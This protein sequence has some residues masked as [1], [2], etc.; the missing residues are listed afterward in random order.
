MF[1]DDVENPMVCDEFWRDYD[2]NEWLRDE[3]YYAQVDAAYDG[4]FDDDPDEDC[5]PDEDDDEA[6]VNI[7]TWR[8]LNDYWL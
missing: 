8:K 1:K 2:E 3:I 6:V 7:G 5:L 4:R